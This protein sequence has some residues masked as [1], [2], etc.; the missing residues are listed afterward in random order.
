MS[1]TSGAEDAQKWDRDVIKKSIP[2]AL[3]GAGTQ[4]LRSGQKA[5]LSFL[6]LNLKKPEGPSLR[7]QGFSLH[8]WLTVTSHCPV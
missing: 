4:E 3:H 1:S 8:G 6:S 7:G 2:I 5:L